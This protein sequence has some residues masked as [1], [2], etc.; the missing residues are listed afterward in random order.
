[1]AAHQSPGLPAA[2]P[3]DLAAKRSEI[4]LASIMG[5]VALSHPNERSAVIQ[6]FDHLVGGREQRRRHREAECL[7]RDQIDD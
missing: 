3:P 1:M 2:T 5:S 7:R 4:R 6:L